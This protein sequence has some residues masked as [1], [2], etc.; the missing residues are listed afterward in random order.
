MT[1]G[2]DVEIIDFTLPKEEVL[3]QLKKAD[4][5]I[6]GFSLIFQYYVEKLRKLVRYLREHSINSHF[7]VGGHYPSLRYHEVLNLIPDLDSV[8][9]FE[10]ENTICDLAEC[11]IAGKDCRQ[12]KGIAHRLQ[13]K[14]IS[15][16]LRP[17]M[18]ATKLG[19]S[20]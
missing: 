20:I 9:R 1:K 15:N 18:K 4:P 2:F 13:G 19:M 3:R 17:D 11:L 14:P 16:E 7:T 6:V 10:G 12:I 5:L 8:V